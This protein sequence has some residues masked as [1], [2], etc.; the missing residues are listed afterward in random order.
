MGQ[1]ITH[2][3]E[4]EFEVRSSTGYPGKMWVR[5]NRAVSYKQALQIMEILGEEEPESL[6]DAKE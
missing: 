1:A 4:P 5:L 3:P 6:R 2:E